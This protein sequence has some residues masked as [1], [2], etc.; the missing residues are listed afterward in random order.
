MESH[1]CDKQKNGK[2]GIFKQGHSIT[3][4]A[5]SVINWKTDSYDSLKPA[6][7]KISFEKD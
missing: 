7:G 4:A 1:S 5:A 3:L 2:N 6:R